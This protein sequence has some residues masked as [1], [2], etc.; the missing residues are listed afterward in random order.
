MEPLW[1]SAPW[2]IFIFLRCVGK[3]EGGGCP[4]FHKGERYIH[5]THSLW[6]GKHS[7]HTCVLA[8]S[9]PSWVE[10]RHRTFRGAGYSV[11]VDGLLFPRS[12]IISN[13]TRMCFFFFSFFNREKRFF[14]ILSY[15]E[16]KETRKGGG[17]VKMCWLEKIS[18]CSWSSFLPVFL[19][20]SRL[21]IVFY[22]GQSRFIAPMATIGLF[23]HQSPWK[24]PKCYGNFT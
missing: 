17:G 14:S 15:I 20:V 8:R 13:H 5:I 24:P 2:S 9:W 7:W 1:W 3:G 12:C 6:K 22:N 23:N 21:F 18:R 4:E 19:F 11:T 16:G 10:L